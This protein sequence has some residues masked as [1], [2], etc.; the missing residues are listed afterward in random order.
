LI[1]FIDINN[2]AGNHYSK[3]LFFQFVMFTSLVMDATTLAIV[4]MVLYVI[5]VMELAL[6]G[7]VTPGGFYQLAAKVCIMFMIYIM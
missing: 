4:K 7:N 1:A 2:E 6:L 3:T 5:I